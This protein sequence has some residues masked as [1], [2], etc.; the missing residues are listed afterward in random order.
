LAL[1]TASDS[2]CAGVSKSLGI[3]EV[4]DHFVTGWVS[5][6][7]TRGTIDILW[8]CLVTTFLC[9]WT[10]LCLNVP[11]ASDS[12]L[13]ILRRRIRWMLH[14]IAGPEFVLGFAAGQYENAH[15]AVADFKDMGHPE[16][17][18]RHAFFADMGGFML[19]PRASKPFP[20]NN[21]HIQWLVVNQYLEFPQVQG[22]DIWDKSKADRLIKSLVCLQ[23]CWLIINVV[24]RAIQ[25]LAITTLELATVSIV[26][27]TI[28]T[29][30]CWLHKPADVKTP[31]QLPCRFSTDEILSG[32]GEAAK[33]PYRMTPLDF[34]DNLGPS[35]S[36]NVMAFAG[37]RSGPQ[38]RPLPR[39]TNDRFPHVRKIRQ[40]L[41]VTITLFSDG[42]HIFGWNFEFPSR[43]E[44]IVWRV[45][46]LVMFLTAAVFWGAEIVAG[47]HRDHVWELMRTVIF[48]P[49]QL[50]DLRKMRAERPRRPQPTPETFPLP[51]ECGASATMWI[52][53]LIAR[54][55]VLIE[56]FVGLRILPRTAY[57]C[58]EWANFFPHIS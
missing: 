26:F 45:A 49:S 12:Q 8:S 15:R 42:I 28:A 43:T 20:V 18:M 22:I 31:I 13:V 38:Q 40:V 51:I 10:V 23:I 55:Y 30:F 52:L 4:P 11:A 56:M 29:F 34:V 6:P 5:Q 3:R 58:V 33:R 53:Y 17:T 16:W 19:Y 27:C 24:A 41:L 57:V 35:W 1:A 46:S 7:N 32:A 50:K 48:R 2:G 39:F 54:A 47:L 9:T 25:K 21:K 37:I 44:Q 36:A 14:A